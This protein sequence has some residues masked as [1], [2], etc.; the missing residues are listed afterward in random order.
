MKGTT[1][2]TGA[3]RRIGR[4]IAIALAE[5]G[6]RIAIHYH[7]SQKDAEATLDAIRKAGGEGA[8]FPC[9]LQNSEEIQQ[10]IPTVIGRFPDL[11]VLINNAS[12]FER[13][14]LSATTPDLF[15]RHMNIH[16][17][18][19][20]LLIQAFAAHCKEGQIINILDTKINQN[21]TSYFAYSLSKKSLHNLTQ[22]TAKALAPSI[23][24]NGIAPGLILPAAQDSEEQ[25]QRMGEKIPLRRTGDAEDIVQTVR[26]FLRSNFITGEVIHVD[27]GE[28]LL[29][30]GAR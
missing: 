25:F 14:D 1:L 16:V 19:P 8:L 18:A 17:K 3:G 9:D 26:F 28:H 29:K 7:H 13:A 23:R 21:L 5:D 4:A 20:F 30:E 22:L 24:V 11:C 6:Y 12:V 27:G 15:D 2:I 10:L